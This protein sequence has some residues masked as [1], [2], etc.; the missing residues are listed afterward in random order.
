MGM[1]YEV[2]ESKVWMRDDGKTASIYGACPYYTDA[3]AARWK[4]VTRGWT[5]FD[6]QSN[7]VGLGRQPFATKEE[8]QAKADE[9]N[10]K[11]I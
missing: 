10:A 7:T 5:I 3:E 1:R 9:L 11:R 8:A 4:V 6:T 2:I